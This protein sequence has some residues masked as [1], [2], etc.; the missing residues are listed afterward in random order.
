MSREMLKS[1]FGPLMQSTL[2]AFSGVEMG[3]AQVI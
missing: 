1:P 2:K 3:K